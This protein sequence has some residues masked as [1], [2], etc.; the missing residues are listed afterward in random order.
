MDYL[1]T[2]SF[3]SSRRYTFIGFKK[4]FDMVDLEQIN[5]GIDFEFHIN[6][7]IGR[8]LLEFI[9]Q[10]NTNFT[11]ANAFTFSIFTS[12]LCLGVWGSHLASVLDS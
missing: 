9:K 10:N 4:A 11:F 7:A 12:L 1:E 3:I 2:G 8:T 5:L 6:T